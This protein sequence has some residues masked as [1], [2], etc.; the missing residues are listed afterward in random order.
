MTPPLDPA[1][2]CVLIVEDNPGDRRMIELTLSEVSEPRFAVRTA[3]RLAPALAEIATGEV[4]VVLLDLSLPD[5]Y[6]LDTFRAVRSAA[7][8][9]PVV[10]MSGLDDNDVALAAVEAGAQDYLPKSTV[11]ERELVRALQYAIR[12]S[13]GTGAAERT[14][15]RGTVVAVVGAKG[16]VGSTTLALNL[17]SAL[18]EGSSVVLC[19][20]DVRYGD[21]GFLLGLQS[22]GGLAEVARRTAAG[23]ALDEDFWRGLILSSGHGFAVVG[24]DAPDQTVTEAQPEHVRRLVEELRR[25]FDLVVLDTPACPGE[26][27]LEALR[28]AD[29][30]L[31]LCDPY[32]PATKNARILLDRLANSG[33]SR[34]AVSVVLNRMGLEEG[35]GVDRLGA[36]LGHP[37]QAAITDSPAVAVRTS[38]HGRLAIREVPDSLFSQ[39]IRE[40]AKR[41]Q[42]PV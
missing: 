1:A 37:I 38:Q 32:R 7:P 36:D 5:S 33:G 24:A 31:L 23:A 2:I 39:Q 42:G 11:E 13:K 17:A 12:R 40:L 4:H 10:V 9:L 21:V 27:V 8:S 6:G 3:D 19:D 34:A 25:R 29:R 35:A 22:P 26:P 20:L 14:D 18:G 30:V 16:G 41:L 28:M 15:P